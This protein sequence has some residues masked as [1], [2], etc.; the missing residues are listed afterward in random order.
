MAIAMNIEARR[1][2]GWDIQTLN[3]NTIWVDHSGVEWDMD[4]V[5]HFESLRSAIGGSLTCA[6]DEA[7]EHIRTQWL[8]GIDRWPAAMIQCQ[9]EFDIQVCL[10]FAQ[11][12]DIPIAIREEGQVIDQSVSDG[13]LLIDLSA[14]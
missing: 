4:Y 11:R 1:I 13:V 12:F 9:E 14:M 5:A 8:E 7:Y 2:E 3:G 6:W 10:A